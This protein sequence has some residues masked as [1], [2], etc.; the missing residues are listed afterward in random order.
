VDG[1]AAASASLY[2]L[3]NAMTD[4]PVRLTPNSTLNDHNPLINCKALAPNL[5]VHGDSA[6]Y[7]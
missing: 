7:G 1:G 5:S 3:E 4:A 2:R 6:N